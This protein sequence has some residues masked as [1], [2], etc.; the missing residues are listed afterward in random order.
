MEP[1]S[2]TI[3]TFIWTRNPRL[4]AASSLFSPLMEKLMTHSPAH[5]HSLERPFGYV[6]LQ[7]QNKGHTK[8]AN[9]PF[10]QAF[11]LCCHILGVAS[12]ELC[13]S[14]AHAKT[15]CANSHLET[16]SLGRDFDHFVGKLFF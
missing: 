13:D 4:S 14:I 12:A 9:D 7:T 5:R 1:G 2:E 11:V 16:H 15:L 6:L 8:P 3:Q 10:E